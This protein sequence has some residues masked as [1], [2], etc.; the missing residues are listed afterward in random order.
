MS[1]STST[2]V[3]LGA[4]PSCVKRTVTFDRVDG[5]KGFIPV[6]FVFM[7]RKEFAAKVAENTEITKAQY[8]DALA[9][10]EAEG[11]K[12]TFAEDEDLEASAHARWLLT[13][14]EGWGLD[15]DLNEHNVRQLVDELPAGAAA[16][17]DEFARLSRTGRLG[18]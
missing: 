15:V 3:V 2:K 6:S 12:L 7:T 8:T 4:R 14:L 5:S 16:I 17:N 11:R 18:N 13:I 1:S 9:R 10:A